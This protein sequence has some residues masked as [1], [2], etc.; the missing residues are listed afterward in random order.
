MGSFEAFISKLSM[1]ENS[2]YLQEEKIWCW[3][4]KP[5]EK[6][7]FYY[8]NGEKIMFRIKN[9]IFDQSN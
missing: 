6:Q 4:V 5:D 9:C 7:I 2:H 8:D 3:L 1:K